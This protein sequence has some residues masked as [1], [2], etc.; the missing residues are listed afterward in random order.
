M[1]ILLLTKYSRMG[2]SSRLRSL[3][4]LPKL[5]KQGFQ[6]TVQ[7]LFDDKYLNSLYSN[8]S[9]SKL[10]IVRYYLKRLYALT[11]VRQYDIIWIEKEVFPYFPAL[12]EQFL[13][14]IGIKYIVDYDDAIFHNYDSS[15]NKIIRL[16]LSRKID[17][18]MKNASCVLAGNSYLAERAKLAGAKNIQLLPTVVDHY[19]YKNNSSSINDILTIGWIGS[20]STQKYVIEILPILLEVYNQLPF[21]L[22]LVGATETIS[23]DLPGLDV[24]IHS[25][26]ENTETDL[27]NT[28][29]IGIMPLHDG[30]WEKGKCG[31]KLIQYMACG[32]PVVASDVG[33]NKVI[34][35]DQESGFVVS[36]KDDWVDRLLQLLSSSSIRNEKG[37]NGRSTVRKKY[38]IE[39]QV[40]NLID[41]LN[42][43]GKA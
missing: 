4:Y 38:S 22:L 20:P 42:S 13:S 25:W 17:K 9:R 40:I 6:I 39:S 35:G 21:R 5:N 7:S 36:K 41:I 16:F 31:Y 24:V 15:K 12:V 19:R 3:Q 18:V 33:V 10:A 14:L 34:I 32:V 37:D 23:E 29:D 43:N 1:K 26:S 8:K 28:M 30:P 11:K 2:A 27:I